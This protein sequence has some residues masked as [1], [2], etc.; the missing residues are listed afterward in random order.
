VLFFFGGGG[1]GSVGGAVACHAAIAATF[2]HCMHDS[3]APPAGTLSTSTP[4]PPFSP[5][6]STRLAGRSTHAQNKKRGQKVDKQQGEPR[7]SMRTAD[8]QHVVSDV[9]AERFPQFAEHRGTVILP[10]S[11]ALAQERSSDAPKR[12][13]KWSPATMGAC[14]D[15]GACLSVCLSA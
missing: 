3:G 8:R 5:S 15:T 1:G 9:D 6:S 12:P 4:P 13:Q 2:F 10:G 14:C 7:P 11:S